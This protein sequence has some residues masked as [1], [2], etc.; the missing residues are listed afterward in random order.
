MRDVFIT[1]CLEHIKDAIVRLKCEKQDS[2][3]KNM[4][5]EHFINARDSIYEYLCA[6]SNKSLLHGYI[7]ADMVISTCIHIPK[8]NND[9]QTSDKY[10]G[11]ALS[12]L[13]KV[14]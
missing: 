11:I 8:D 2:V 1:D 14:V 10:R 9:M 5:S 6:L 13:C 4:A 3:Y 12:A 7:S